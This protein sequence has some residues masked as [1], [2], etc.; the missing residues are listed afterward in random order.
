MPPNSYTSQP[1]TAA[2]ALRVGRIVDFSRGGR[3]PLEPGD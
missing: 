2:R 1:D 3:Q